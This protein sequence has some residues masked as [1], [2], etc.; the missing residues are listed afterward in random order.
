MAKKKPAKTNQT[1]LWK[2]ILIFWIVFFL[3]AGC[4]SA[5]FYSIA[6]GAFGELPTFEILENPQSELASEVYS[7]DSVLLGKYYRQNRSNARFHELPKNL[8]DAL[9]ATEDVR[10]YQHSGIDAKGI[11]RAVTLR[12]RRGGGSTITQQ[13]AKNLFPREKLNK[14]KLV[15]R[16]IQEWI[17]AVRLE[18]CYTKEEIIIMYLNT[19]EFSSN[20]YG[21]K[22]AAKTYFNKATDSLSIDESAI[23]VGMLQAPSRYNPQRNPE[24]SKTRR[25]VVLYQMNRYNFIADTEF[26]SLKQLPIVLEYQAPSHTEGLA[27]YFRE[28]LRFQLQRWLNESQKIDSSRKYNLYTDGLK[29]Y[30]TL[31]SRLQTLAEKAV[32]QH[33]QELQKEFDKESGKKDLWATQQEEL[34]K[35]IKNSERYRALSK[36]EGWQHDS[37]IVNFSEPIPMKIFTYEGEKDTVMTPLDS[38]RYHRRFLQTGMLA[39]DPKSGFIKAWVGGINYKYFQFDHITTK[40]QIGSTFK[41]FLYTTAIDNGWSPCFKVIDQPYTFE[42]FNNWTPQNSGG[43]FTY[44][45]FT[46][47][48]CLADSKNSCSAYLMKQIGP[49]PLI[50]LTRRLGI[51]S[52]IDPY[53]SI[54]L[55]TPDITV[56]EMVGAYTA[57][58]NKGVYTKPIFIT[59]IEDKNGNLIQSFPTESIEVM[60]EQT[61]WIMVEMLRYIVKTGTGTRLWSSRYEYQLK[62]DIGG[63]TGTTQNHSDGWFLGITPQLIAGVWVGGEDRFMRFE[64]MSLGQGASMAL[65]IW[66]LFFKS[67]YENPAL[68]YDTEITFE[69]PKQKLTIELDCSRYEKASEFE[70]KPK[71]YGDEFEN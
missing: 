56:Q 39:V 21:I 3:F 10:Y 54:C 68:G 5:F 14:F 42:E 61:A 30:T 36:D 58:A 19:V 1:G 31:D 28:Y 9:I 24:N 63:K 50:D 23:L 11:V 64:R 40:R 25:N 66:A 12:G 52:H 70:Y 37:I 13:L 27:P 32:T 7:A 49:Q 44:E 45:K 41:P 17:I 67:I 16:K 34:Q 51:V 47:L 2:Y 69:K 33:M 26:D 46:L 55:G 62:N 20:S 38:L 60:S 48:D 65:P 43:K 71:K 53:P 59:H 22:S 4:I 35:A 8:V 6:A 29:I 18:R 57:F 15:I